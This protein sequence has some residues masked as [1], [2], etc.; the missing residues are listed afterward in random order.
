[1]KIVFWGTPHFAVP[2]LE[3]IIQAGHEVSCVISQP[4]RRRGR[5]S[6]ISPSPVKN[7]AM[8]M[9]IPV[10]TPNSVRKDIELNQ[11][12]ISIQADIFI[13]VAFGQI[14]P[15]SILE[16]P[17]LTIDSPITIISSSSVR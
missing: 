8:E 5:G 9:N 17:S 4:D 10:F 14:L 11:A 13:V 7:R 1:M 6:S 3:A 15:K 16:I 12:L 2:S